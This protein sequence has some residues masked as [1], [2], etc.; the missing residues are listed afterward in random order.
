MSYEISLG[1]IGENNREGNNK[2]TKV[3]KYLTCLHMP[4]P[5]I[6]YIRQDIQQK[7]CVTAEQRTDILKQP[8]LAKRC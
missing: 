8:L 5:S 6:K 4:I 7:T 2:D 1:E 3:S